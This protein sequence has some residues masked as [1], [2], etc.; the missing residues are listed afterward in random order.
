MTG[1]RN[2]NQPLSAKNEYYMAFLR[3]SWLRKASRSLPKNVLDK[4]WPAAPPALKDVSASLERLYYAHLSRKYRLSLSPERKTVLQ[5]KLLGS[6]LFKGRKALYPKSVPIYYERLRGDFN[7]HAKKAAFEKVMA[8][9]PDDKAVI[10][11]ANI[12][13]INRASY[14]E[15]PR[16]LVVTHAAMFILDAK[17]LAVKIRIPYTEMT[18]ITV[19]GLWDG[20][21]VAHTKAEMKGDKGDYIIQ[22]SPA[23]TVVE[24]I[25]RVVEAK[26]L[27]KDQIKC[28]NTIT[29]TNKGGKTGEIRCSEAMDQSAPQKSEPGVLFIVAPPL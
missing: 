18:G 20:V 28:E 3:Q 7:T 23:T 29:H 19:S 24:M 11:A 10:Y 1:F 17:S 4:N 14:K 13:K 16:I 22:L 26:G 5:E 15:V 8:K 25:V 21:V 12:T 9:T 27:S 6:E 2:R